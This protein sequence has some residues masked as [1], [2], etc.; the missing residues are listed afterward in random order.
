MIFRILR[1]MSA[2]TNAF[3]QS[4]SNDKRLRCIMLLQVHGELCVC[5]LTHALNIAQPVISRHLALLRDAGLVQ[6]RRNG[7]W[8]YYRIS[9][10]LPGWVKQVLQTTAKANVELSPFA[11]DRLALIDMPNRPGAACCA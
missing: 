4:L 5:E 6:D 3:F 7:Q 9:T 1:H 2:D 11:D 8:I 10:E